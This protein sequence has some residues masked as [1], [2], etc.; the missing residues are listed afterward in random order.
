MGPILS[1]GVWI[2]RKCGDRTRKQ[3]GKGDP[4]LETES[5]YERSEAT[6]G[7][8]QTHFPL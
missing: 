2:P 3:K 5:P 1:A 7:D 4:S 8:S 6:D